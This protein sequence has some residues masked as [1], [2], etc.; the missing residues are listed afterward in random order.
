MTHSEQF[1]YIAA[2]RY[3]LYRMTAAPDI[4]VREIKKNIDKFSIY[5]LKL[6][7][8]EV[9]ARE[10]VP[11]DYSDIINLWKNFGNYLKEQINKAGIV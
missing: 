8:S 4:V 10:N 7:L 6:M 11:Y 9:E 3:S 2:L 1:I 5:N